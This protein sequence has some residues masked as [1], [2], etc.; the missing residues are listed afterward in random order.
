VWE[1]KFYDAYLAYK[2]KKESI[3]MV[4]LNNEV[5]LD[6]KLN[7]EELIKDLKKV[8]REAKKAT[9]AIKEYDASSKKESEINTLLDLAGKYGFLLTA[10]DSTSRGIGKTP[11]LVQKAINENL[12]ILVGSSQ[13]ARHIHETYGFK[14][15]ESCHALGFSQGRTK[16][17]ECNGFLVDDLVPSEKIVQF[18]NMYNFS[19]K[20]GFSQD[21]ININN[22]IT[23]EY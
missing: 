11:A 16:I 12:A 21:T 23:K 15:T 19:F 7:T 22:N 2:T 8:Q 17:R 9:Q 20:G 4:K 6:I 1:Q 3:N 13:M 14:N 18:A 10:T 5:T